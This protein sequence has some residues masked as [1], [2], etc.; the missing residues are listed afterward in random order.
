L[1]PL[2]LSNASTAAGWA[3]TPSSARAGLPG[4]RWNIK[5]MIIVTMSSTTIDCA[6]RRMV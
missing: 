4:N 5:N 2:S 6:A 1:K 3:L